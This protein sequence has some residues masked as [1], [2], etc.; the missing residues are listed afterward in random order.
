MPPRSKA[1]KACQ[2]LY[3]RARAS[4]SKLRVPRETSLPLP[5]C[6]RSTASDEPLGGCYMIAGNSI[7]LSR[8]RIPSPRAHARRA[9]PL[10][11]IPP[12]RWESQQPPR[13]ETATTT[14]SGD[15]AL[16]AH[17]RPSAS[18]SPHAQSCDNAGLHKAYLATTVPASPPSERNT[19]SSSSTIYR[20]VGIP[21]TSRRRVHA[22]WTV[23]LLGT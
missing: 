2:R 12:L 22:T 4:P 8:P 5:A 14:V 23:A 15:T 7:H 1:E 11:H 13:P 21:E 10:R 19:W 20:T 18:G 3:Q 16:V 17:T 6:Q 9:P